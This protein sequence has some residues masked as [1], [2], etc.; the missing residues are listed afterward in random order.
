[1]WKKLLLVVGL[2]FIRLPDRRHTYASLLIQN[3]EAWAYVKEQPGHHSIKITIDTY[4]HLAP[5]GNKAAVDRLE[6]ATIRNP[7][8]T[9]TSL[10]GAHKIG[11]T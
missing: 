10:A 3:G 9:S 2:H 5:G 6:D 8:A 1:V 7:D 11:S 4:G